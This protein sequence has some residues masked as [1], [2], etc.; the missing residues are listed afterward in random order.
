MIPKACADE[1]GQDE[2]FDSSLLQSH[3]EHLKE[4]RENGSVSELM[5]AVRVDLLRNTG[6]MCDRYYKTTN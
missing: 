6:N 1:I 2:D 4:V 3:T 5:L